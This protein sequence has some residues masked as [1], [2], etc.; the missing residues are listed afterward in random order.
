MRPSKT[1]QHPPFFGFVG[2]VYLGLNRQINASVRVLAGRPERKSAAIVHP[3]F[4]DQA[5]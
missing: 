1:W 2:K 4:P 5:G 3:F